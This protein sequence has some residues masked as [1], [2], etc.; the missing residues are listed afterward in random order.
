[1]CLGRPLQRVHLQI[2]I[3]V[4]HQLIIHKNVIKIHLIVMLLCNISEI[5]KD[6]S[7]NF[8]YKNITLNANKPI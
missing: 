5:D 8:Q 1:M 7:I 4:H 2:L 3:V 6:V